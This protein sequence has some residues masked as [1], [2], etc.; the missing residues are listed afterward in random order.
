MKKIIL[1][2]FSL[3]FWFGCGKE[4]KLTFDYIS[5][6]KKACATCATVTI[7]IP[8]AL[9]KSKIDRTINAAIKEEIIYLLNFDENTE[10][11]DI[12][13]AIN[14]FLKGYDELKLKYAEAA[15]PW[16][17]NIN[18]Y[19]A[20]ENE[21]LLTVRLDSY[22]FTGGAHGYSSVRFLNFDKEKGIELE[23]KE[24]F[25]NEGDFT[26]FAEVK[27]RS[28]EHV[29][30]GSSINSTG[31]MFETDSFY[32]PENIG[33]TQEG[34]QLFYKPYE[35]ASYADGPIVLTLPFKEIWSYL[36]FQVKS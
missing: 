14:S 4:G 18:G 32:L 8:E 2:S 24:L 9:N 17:A 22:L 11:M 34:L 12:D 30:Q 23:N 7:S 5:F 31:F 36:M 26:A 20:Y 25:V 10:T 13:M 35:I 19:I 3:F 6:E 1:Y 29:P 21:R 27:F 15:T 33:Y 16:E 28:Q